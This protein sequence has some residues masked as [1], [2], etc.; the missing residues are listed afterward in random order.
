M[1]KNP[2]MSKKPGMPKNPEMQKKKKNR[3]AKK[4]PSNM[5]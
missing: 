2:E 3:N 1:P 5:N 4:S